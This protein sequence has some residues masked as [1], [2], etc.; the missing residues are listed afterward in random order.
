[1]DALGC[2]AIRLIASE[3]Q[4]SSTASLEIIVSDK[5]PVKT[6]TEA[7]QGQTTGVVRWMLGI[8][9]ALAIVALIVAYWVS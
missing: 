7:R 1:M 8:S 3:L 6:A 5:P 9:M 2:L 4:D